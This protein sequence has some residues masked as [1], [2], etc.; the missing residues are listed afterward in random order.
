MKEEYKIV[1][2]LDSV[3]VVKAIYRRKYRYIYS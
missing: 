2:I 3:K 1:G